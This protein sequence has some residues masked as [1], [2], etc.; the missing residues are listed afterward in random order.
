VSTIEYNG[1]R[2]WYQESGRGEPM[3]FLHNG[4][5]DHRIWD[6]QV[7]YFSKT[8]RV[9]VVDHLGHGRSDRPAIE[10]TLPLFTGEVAALVEQLDLAPV[11]LVGHCIGGA[12]SLN[13]T[14]AHPENVRALVLFNVATEKTLCAGPLADM[15]RSFSSDRAAREQ[16]IEGVEAATIPREESQ[17]RLQRQL[18][19]SKV[20]DDLEF[21]EHIYRLHSLKGQMRTLFNTISHFDSYRGLDV[22]EKPANF[23]PVC[24]FWGEANAILPSSAGREF[25]DRLRPDKFEPLSGCGHLAM[26]EHAA[27]VNEKIEAFLAAHTRKMV[28]AS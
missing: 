2:V 5:N 16:F 12:M 21:A 20:A 4:G 14:L 10:Y 9:I 6:H 15:Y 13:Y 28:Q 18:G 27:E 25:S 3:V 1:Y 8:H 26:R 24:L 19:E 7:E 23:P 17:A 22:L 11:M